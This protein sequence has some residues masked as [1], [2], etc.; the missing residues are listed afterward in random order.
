MNTISAPVNTTCVGL[1]ASMGAVLLAGGTGTRSSL[2]HSRI[3]I[4]Q[5]SSGARGTSAD[6]RIQMAETNKL[7]DQLFQIL[8]DATGK[9]KKQI[10]KDCDRDYY[11]SAKEAMDYGLIDTVIESKKNGRNS[12]N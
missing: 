11:M 7:E 2:P 6:L 1:A 10:A 5:V 8:A 4:H 3:M 9:N 12:Q